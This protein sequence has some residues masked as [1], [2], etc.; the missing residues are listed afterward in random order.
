MLKRNYSRSK[1]I[2]LFSVRAKIG[3]TNRDQKAGFVEVDSEK[4]IYHK[5]YAPDPD[6]D[7]DIALIK[8]KR[9]ISDFGKLKLEIKISFF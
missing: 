8:L 2:F 1:I 6:I 3:A 5:Q 9:G 7:Y 4:M